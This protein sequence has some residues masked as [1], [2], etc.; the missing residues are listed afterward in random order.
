MW[1]RY[2]S[3]NFAALNW[4]S[5]RVARAKQV[6]DTAHRTSTASAGFATAAPQALLNAQLLTFLSDDLRVHQSDV[7]GPSP[8]ST[9]TTCCRM[10]TCGA[11]NLTPGAAYMVFIISSMRLRTCRVT[12]GT[13]FAFLCKI[14]AG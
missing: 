3:P 11:A 14:R 2:G 4:S 13:L 10:P 7:M 6:T 5:A 9:T 1:M 12:F 8:T